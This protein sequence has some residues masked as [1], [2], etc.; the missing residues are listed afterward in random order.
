MNRNAVTRDSLR[1]TGDSSS[2]PTPPPSAGGGFDVTG[3]KSQN[4]INGQI[5]GKSQEVFYIAGKLTS[6]PISYAVAGAYPGGTLLAIPQ[7]FPRAGVLDLVGCQMAFG[8]GGAGT[9][10]QFHVGI[11]SNLGDPGDGTLYPGN[12][13]WQGPAWV[14]AAPSINVIFNQVIVPAISVPA[15]ALLWFVYEISTGIDPGGGSDAVPYYGHAVMLQDAMAPILGQNRWVIENLFLQLLDGVGWQSAP[16]IAPDV[17]HDP[18]PATF[19]DTG[20]EQQITNA[21]FGGGVPVIWYRF[22]K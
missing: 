8:G 17:W 21:N 12:L 4:T 1:R 2:S 22:Q 15:G 20:A 9:D 10:P 13:L 3:Y 14:P 16:V 11:Y 18:M 6:G 7:L 19:P 5:N